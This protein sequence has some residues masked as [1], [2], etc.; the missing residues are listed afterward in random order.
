VSISAPK[1]LTAC[2]RFFG[3]PATPRQRQYEALRAY[4][5][6]QR[7]SA[8]I[9]RR[10]G[11]S[12][13]AFRVLCHAFRRDELPPFFATAQPGPRAQPHK[14]RAQEQIVALRK[15]NYSIYEISQ[16]LKDHGMPLSS[17]AVREVLAAEGFAPLP[18]RLDEE[19]PSRVGPSVEAVTDVRRFALERVPTTTGRKPPLR[20]DKFFGFRGELL[21][22]A[23]DAEV[24]VR[25][26]RLLRTYLSPKRPRKHN[27]AGQGAGMAWS[28]GKSASFGLKTRQS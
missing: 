17:R 23:S 15:R 5:V 22:R 16:A 21:R 24:K 27:E 28:N 25:T 10:F 19:R 20:T 1:D 14:S 2:R 8:E 4:F 12:P 11:Y 26:I 9:A 3:E 13:G 7:P 18:R 6:E